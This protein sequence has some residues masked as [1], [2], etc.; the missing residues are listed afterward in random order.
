MMADLPAVRV[1]PSR[2]WATTGVDFA[3][4][5]TLRTH[6]SR[7]PKQYKAWIAIFICLSSHAVHLELVTALSA[8]AYLGAL[9]RFVSRRGRPK[10]I[11]SDNATN[12]SAA[13]KLLK[14][15]Q[16]EDAALREGIEFQFIPP[17]GPHF[18]GMWESNI[19]SLKYHLLRVVG[20]TILNYELM[21]TLLTRVEATL[22]SRPLTALSSDP[23]DLRALTP[24]HFLVQSELHA[25]PEEDLPNNIP[26]LKRWLHI[27]KMAQH[28]WSR[29][30]NEYL[31]RLQ[32]RPKW[33]KPQPNL[34]IG[35]LVL[36]KTDNTSPLQWPLGRVTEIHKGSDGLV[37]VAT[38]RTAHKVLQRPITKLS[39]LPL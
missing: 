25:L 9:H 7:N 33:L 18:G 3:G 34:E 5:I 4:P 15:L 36:I 11:M 30:S 1:T 2:C 8:E 21:Y 12:F 22:N 32:Q 27:Q 29:F 10:K 38:L 24:A 39:P 14:D 31:T 26:P 28:F 37:R 17:G 20:N 35:Q 13:A 23:N 19:K 6:L 16:A